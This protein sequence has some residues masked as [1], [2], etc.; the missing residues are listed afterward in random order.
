MLIQNQ[1]EKHIFTGNITSDEAARMY[2]INEEAKGTVLNFSKKKK[3]KYYDFT[4]F[5]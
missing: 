5:W 3:L 1:H 4:L 2:F